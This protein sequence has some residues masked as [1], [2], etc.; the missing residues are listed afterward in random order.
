MKKKVFAAALALLVL[1]GLVTTGSAGSQSDPLIS[2]SYLT[3]T[4]LADLKARVTQW[5]AR[6][7]QKL[8]DDAEARAEQTPDPEDGW[9]VSSGFVPGEGEYG[10]TV[11]LTAGSGLIWTG[12]T[13]AV[14]SG[15]LVDAT[16]GTE[17]SAGKVLTAG[18]RYLAAEST[19]VVAS[20]QSARWMAE[21]KWRCG[22]GGTVV[23]PL[24][25][26]DVP[27][28]AWYYDDVRYVWEKGLVS[29]VSDTEFNPK[30]TMERGMATTLLYRL[31]KEPAVSY[32]PVFSDVPDGQWYTD[33]IIWCAGVG[34]V[35]GMG[36]GQF[37]PRQ[38][39]TRQH[40]ATILYNYAVKT[41]RRA[42]ERGNLDT[43]P[44]GSAV[45]SW[46]KEGMS[47][48]VGA[49]IFQGDDTG[50]LLP[51]DEADRSQMAAIIHHYMNWLDA[52]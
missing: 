39:V 1:L 23:V 45:A 42:D 27:E 3:E 11:T 10:S 2:L 41:G 5:V 43:F 14:S 44:D 25:F 31:A 12:G 24:P 30:G 9:T 21:G 34:I 28:G 52:Q 51:G 6:D 16:A 19:V 36:D 33:G 35:S 7:T 40:I 50:K 48:A 46:A 8:Y 47:W 13:G 32:S 26:T 37:A 38:N 29:G 22:T 49:G 15:V 18:H 4:F 20:S 17:L